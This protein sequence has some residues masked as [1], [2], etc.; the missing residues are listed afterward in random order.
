MKIE[1][2]QNENALFSDIKIGQTFQIGKTL[3]LKI[4]PKAGADGLKAEISPNA[5]D[6]KTG[7]T[8]SISDATSVNDKGKFCITEI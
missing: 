6:L 4:G 1:F 8:S 3:Y 7:F 5:V 2:L